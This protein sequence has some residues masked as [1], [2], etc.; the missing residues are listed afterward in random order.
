MTRD[1]IRRIIH[2]ALGKWQAE[3]N[4]NFKEVSSEPADILVS[5]APGSHGD[6]Y[7][8]DGRGGTLAHAYYP[9]KNFGMSMILF[10][11]INTEYQISRQSNILLKCCTPKQAYVQYLCYK[12]CIRCN[13]LR[14]LE[15]NPKACC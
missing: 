10:L 13:W 4:I 9:Y 1:N 12:H 3:A 15:N 7:P 14:D 8:F 11:N 5:F 2:V 6:P